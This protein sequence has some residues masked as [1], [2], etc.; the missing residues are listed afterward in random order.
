[1]KNY[2]RYYSTPAAES[3]RCTNLP[4]DSSPPSCPYT[5]LLLP[6]PG[7]EWNL[8]P[9]SAGSDCLPF[10]GK[11]PQSGP[12]PRLPETKCLVIHTCTRLHYK[13][14]DPAARTATSP[15]EPA[16]PP[17]FLPYPP[18]P[19]IQYIPAVPK[20]YR[21]YQYP[22]PLPHVSIR[23]LSAYPLYSCPSRSYPH[24]S[25]WPTI[26]SSRPAYR[27]ASPLP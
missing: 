26:P 9:H 2:G 21:A 23:S 7:Y 16:A 15:A 24:P 12:C 13:N 3:Y 11:Q 25:P 1:M 8:L 20:P 18:T 19:E 6:A 5:P 17:A 10:A 27:Y 22:G 4:A 14:Q